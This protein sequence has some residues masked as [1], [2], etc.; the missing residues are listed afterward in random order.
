[1]PLREDLINELQKLRINRETIKV[2][3]KKASK[4]PKPSSME[5]LQKLLDEIEQEGDDL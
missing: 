2:K 3:Q 1:V 4:E 5:E